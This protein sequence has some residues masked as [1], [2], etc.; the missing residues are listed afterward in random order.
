MAQSIH[1]LLSWTLITMCRKVKKV[2]ILC[3]TECMQRTFV[4]RIK[5]IFLESFNELLHTL[6]KKTNKLVQPIAVNCFWV[7]DAESLA[8]NIPQVF[9]GIQIWETGQPVHA[10]DLVLLQGVIDH[11]NP[12]QSVNVVL[13]NGA[14]SNCLQSLQYQTVKIYLSSHICHVAFHQVKGFSL[15]YP[16]PPQATVDSPQQDR[17]SVV[18]VITRR[19]L[20]HHIRTVKS[21]FY[22]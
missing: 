16:H 4:S 14:Q 17:G 22:Q 8:W 9:R 6:A 19:I 11:T 13:K 2:S 1:T 20:G 3:P 21:D 5:R 15:I 10:V 12:V 18:P 7:V